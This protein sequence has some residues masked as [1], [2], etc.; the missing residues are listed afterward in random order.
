M[1]FL[2]LF[3]IGI[4]A[5]STLEQNGKWIQDITKD[6]LTDNKTVVLWLEATSGRGTYGEIATLIIRCQNNKTEM[7]INWNAYLGLDYIKVIDRIDSKKA[8]TSYWDISTDSKASFK[9]T[10]VSY[11][12]KMLNSKKYI[13]QVTPYR[14]NPITAVFETEGLGKVIKELR[15]T[16]HW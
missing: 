14:E 3:C 9:R 4:F 13:A 16:C 8:E 6:E 7:Y 5:S 11:I 12:K 15:E 1:L 10:P 2:G